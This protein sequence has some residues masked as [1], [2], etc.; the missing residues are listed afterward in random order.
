MILEITACDKD[1][2]TR[3][4]ERLVWDVMCF[5]NLGLCV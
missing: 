4:K 3:G 2:K 5:F 1:T